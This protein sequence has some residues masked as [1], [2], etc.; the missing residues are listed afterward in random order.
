MNNTNEA[1]ETLKNISNDETMSV[2]ERIA[3]VQSIKEGAVLM[4][5]TIALASALTQAAR[6]GGNGDVLDIVIT[7]VIKILNASGPT[8]G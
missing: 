3:L 7:E 8:P 6:E 1:A 5:D 2:E 4:G